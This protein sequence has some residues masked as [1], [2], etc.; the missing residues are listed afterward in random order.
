MAKILIADDDD[1]LVDL[2]QFRLESDGHDVVAAQ[3][4]LE[5]IALIDAELPDLVI[6]DAMMPMKTGAE[7]LTEMRARDVS[8]SIP[9]IMLTA[10][11]GQDDIV[12]A[13]QSGADDYLTKPFI[14]QEL[15]AR[16]TLLL[17]KASLTA[18]AY[19]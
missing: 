15:S 14:P 12:T 17:A 19:G 18:G 5:A 13:L 7:V 10:R 6:L 16:I 4:G 1:I 8:R 2:V 3:D 11:K 9:V